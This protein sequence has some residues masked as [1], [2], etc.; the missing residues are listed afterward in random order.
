MAIQLK[1]TNG[2]SQLDLMLALF[3]PEP[4]GHVRMVTFTLQGVDWPIAGIDHRSRE[5]K[6]EAELYD[7][8]VGPAEYEI[9]VH[10][11][12][13]VPL[14]PT[15]FR[16]VGFDVESCDMVTIM[17]YSTKKRSGMAL[18]ERL[19]GDPDIDHDVV[20]LNA[21]MFRKTRCH[22]CNWP[23]YTPEKGVLDGQFIICTK[24]DDDKDIPPWT[25]DWC[26]KSSPDSVQP[27][28]TYDGGTI[29]SECFERDDEGPQIARY[30]ID[31]YHGENEPK[32]VVDADG[33]VDYE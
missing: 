20:A 6:I 25:C 2:P 29:C 17:D 28:Q 33:K 15:S 8:N 12:E 31:A 3:D 16:V 4:H 24:C 23:I 21:H 1:V 30:G 10:A 5:E 14:D 7:Q 27:S 18:L 22:R 9:L 32:C 13:R 19:S 26:G 11:V